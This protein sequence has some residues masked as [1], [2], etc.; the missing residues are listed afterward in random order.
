MVQ[1]F[2]ALGAQEK[3]LMEKMFG[4]LKLTARGYHK[5]LKVART[6]ADLDGSENIEKQHLCEALCFR[7][8]TEGGTRL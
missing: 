8:D 1:K 6:I 7:A 2:C 4:R 3:A 5:I